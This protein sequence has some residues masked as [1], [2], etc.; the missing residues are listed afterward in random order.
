MN[1][2]FLLDRSDS[3]P[4]ATG[5]G[6]EYVNG[7]VRRDRGPRGVSCSAT[8]R[9]SNHPQ[10]PGDVQKLHAVVAPTAATSP[11]PSASH[12]R[13]SET[14]RATGLLSDGNETSAT[15]GASLGRS[16]GVSVDVVPWVWRG[17]TSRPET[18]RAGQPQ[19]GQTSSGHLRAIGHERSARCGCSRTTGSSA[20][21]RSNWPP[22][23]PVHVSQTLNEPGSTPTTC[24]SM[25]PGR[26]AQNNRPATSPASRATPRARRL[27]RSAQDVPRRGARASKLDTRLS[28]LGG[29][30]HP[31]E[32]QSYDA[33]FL[34]NIAAA[35]WAT[36][37]EP[38]RKRVRISASPRLRRGPD[39]RRAAIAARPR[40]RPAV[41][42]ELSSKKSCPAA[43]WCSSCTAWS[44]TTGTRS[45]R[46]RLGVLDA[47]PQD[48]MG[49]VLWT[50]G[51][52]A[53]PLGR[54]ATARKG[55]DDLGMNQG[56]LPS[57]ENVMH[58][59]YAGAE[60]NPACATRRRTSGT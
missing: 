49:V 15:L 45:P 39:L 17:G 16:L 31:R 43:R 13:L 11:A 48:E 54:S 32:M 7:S 40:V 33:I 23:E 35:T 55:P 42:M 29:F 56:D 57:F 4:R 34:S 46:M 10:Q 38:A 12:R 60:G 44:S 37:P 18:Q 8:A 2:F 50:E 9:P 28:D 51:P 19:E 5:A 24:S 41:E 53:L 25:C 26:V 3:V 14:A 47:S 22:Q 27:G 58:M 21:K 36:P 20:N 6:R 30:P 52:L 59:A 1:L